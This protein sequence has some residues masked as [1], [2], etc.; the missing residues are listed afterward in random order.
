MKTCGYTNKTIDDVEMSDNLT[1]EAAYMTA[2][3]HLRTAF[4]N[5]IMP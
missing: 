1:I 3:T 4:N 2:L 5:K